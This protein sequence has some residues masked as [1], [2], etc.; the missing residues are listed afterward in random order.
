M[1]D[2]E[3]G[4][5]HALPF[6]VNAQLWVLLIII[7]NYLHL[8]TV[9]VNPEEMNLQYSWREERRNLF[10]G[11]IFLKISFSTKV[12]HVHERNFGKYRRPQGRKVLKI[13]PFSPWEITIANILVHIPLFIHMQ[14]G[15]PAILSVSPIR[16]AWTLPMPFHMLPG[17]DFFF[18]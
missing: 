15:A 11:L 2:A 17:R 18:F 10:L 3:L 16:S 12:R 14:I 1:S 5:F 6:V 13:T 7:N 9:R 8:L 4:A